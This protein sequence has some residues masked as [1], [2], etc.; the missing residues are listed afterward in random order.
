MSTD[1]WFDIFEINDDTGHIRNIHIK[2]TIIIIVQ[3]TIEENVPFV[4]Q[5]QENDNKSISI[6]HFLVIDCR[7]TNN[8]PCIVYEHFGYNTV[9][10]NTVW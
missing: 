5:S 9:L 3:Y 4:V 2:Y 7:I 1:H 8:P 6:T 10:T